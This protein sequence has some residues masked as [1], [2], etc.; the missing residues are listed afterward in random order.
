MHKLVGYTL[1][2]IAFGMLFMIII[3]STW[4]GIILIVVFVIIGYFLFCFK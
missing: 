1:F 2:W 3:G 4:I